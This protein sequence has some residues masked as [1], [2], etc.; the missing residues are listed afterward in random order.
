V[1]LLPAAPEVEL[2]GARAAAFWLPVD[3]VAP[4]AG[5]V[6]LP[7]PK[8]PEVVFPLLAL[9]APALPF[10]PIPLEVPLPAPALPLAPIPLEDALPMPADPLFKEL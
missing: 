2:I 7:A 10:A 3:P 6:L 1:L 5:V 8:F 9:L 4:V